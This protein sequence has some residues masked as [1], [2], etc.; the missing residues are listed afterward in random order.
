MK[1]IFL[2]ALLLL[3]PGQVH[4]QSADELKQLLEQ[5]DVEIRELKRQLET[6]KR[7]LAPAPLTAAV[8][9]PGPEDDDELSRALERTL[10]QQG[11]LLL[12][13]GSYELQPE[14]SFA[15]WDKSRGPL[16]NEFGAALSFRAGLPWDSQFQLRAPYLHATTATDSTTAWGDIAFGFSKQIATESAT[17]PGLVAS[18]SW[19]GRTGKDGFNGGVPTGAGFNVLGAGLTATKRLDPLMFYG[20]V[21][22]S[23]PQSRRI[24]DVDTAPGDILGVRFG[25]ILAA[26]PQTAVNIGLNLSFEKATRFNGQPLPDSE[27]TAASLQIGVGTVLSR[28]T[29]VNVTG[30]FRLTGNLPN[31]R[32]GVTLPIRF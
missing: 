25:G 22:Y 20:G 3:A 32:L 4:S 16:R 6:L 11:G 13:P 24:A 5:R 26:S 21:S 12:R 18:L 29:L 2:A 9:A 23:M 27:A 15:N 31:F 17:R 1:S 10:V 8:P 7:Q 19:S 28:S 30:D 14:L